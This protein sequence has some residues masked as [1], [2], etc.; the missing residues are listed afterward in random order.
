MPGRQFYMLDDHQGEPGLQDAQSFITGKITRLQFGFPRDIPDTKRIACLLEILGLGRC[1]NTVD[2][3]PGRVSC[4]S[5]DLSRK[6][7]ISHKKKFR[8]FKLH[9]GSGFEYRRNTLF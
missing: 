3:K 8:G 7:F 2:I 6:K 5:H 9:P 4:R 1:Q